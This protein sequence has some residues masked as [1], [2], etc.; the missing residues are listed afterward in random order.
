MGLYAKDA[1][2]TSSAWVAADAAV[3]AGPIRRLNWGCGDHVAPGWINSDIKTG[4]GVDLVC[5]IRRGLPLEDASIDYA[6]TVH[7]LPELSYPEVLPALRELRR[8]MKPRGVLRLVLPDLR[9][10]VRA[11]LLRKD[12]Y[13]KVGDD[14]IQSRG[15][16][17]ILH[18]LWYG[19]S[20][21]LFTTDFAEELLLKANFADVAV[22]RYGQTKSCFPEIVELDNRREESFYMEA[23]KPVKP[24][25]AAPGA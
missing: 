9:K 3:A 21:T 6:V 16:R 11:Y 17:F 4:A 20:R 13:F 1:P 23:T 2:S 14:E 5:D 25:E 10:A 24:R 22:C 15:G 18:M 8:V 19:Y 12:S 7:A